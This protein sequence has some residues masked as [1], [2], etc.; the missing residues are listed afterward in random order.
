MNTPKAFSYT[1]G[2][3][4]Q[5]TLEAALDFLVSIEPDPEE[6]AIACARRGLDDRV[7][8]RKII[9]TH[10]A[11]IA[12]AEAALTQYARQISP[13]T[14]DASARNSWRSRGCQ[15]TRLPSLPPRF[16]IPNSSAPRR[17]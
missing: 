4:D 15:N 12:G 10:A 14:P 1:N 16:A 11:S 5:R 9:T 8:Y 6:F 2:K 13:A 3:V 17:V 7:E